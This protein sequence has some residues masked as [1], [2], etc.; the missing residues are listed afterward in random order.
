LLIVDAGRREPVALRED[1]PP[2]DDAL[3]S[4]DTVGATLDAHFKWYDLPGPPGG[5]EARAEAI[6]EARRT[7]GLT[8]TIDLAAAGRMRF[9]LSSVAFPLPYNTELRSRLDRYGHLLVWPD[10]SAY[11]VLAPGALRAVFGER[12]A[13][14]SPMVSP[15]IKPLVKGSLLGF[16]TERAEVITPMGKVVIEQARIGGV[17]PSGELVCRLLIELV[18]AEPSSNACASELVPL[19]ADYKWTEGGH[20]GFEV[21]TITRRQD[22]AYGQLYVPPIAMFKIGEL[23]PTASGVFLTQADLAALRERAVSAGEPAPGAPGEGLLAQN[24]THTL[25]YVLLDGVPVAWVPP[26]AKQYIIGPRAGRYNVQWRDFFGS[27]VK[28]AKATQLPA[29]I[30]LG[31]ERDG[32]TATTH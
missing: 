16:A 12:R 21:T 32:G 10:G 2:P 25:R 14:V 8:V 28:A 27:D 1:E 24:H 26:R 19:K 7:T 13:D 4:R 3:T 29:R 5:V 17:G 22:L 20:S 11:R 6:K 9:A 23:P 30:E 31:A 15:R 18:S